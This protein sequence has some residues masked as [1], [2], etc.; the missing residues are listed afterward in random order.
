MN[1]KE[2]FG[3]LFEGLKILASRPIFT[4]LSLVLWGLLVAVSEFGAVIAVNFQSTFSNLAWTIVAALVA[5]S[6]VSYFSSGMVGLIKKKGLKEFSRTGRRSW[7]KNLVVIVSVLLMSVVVWAIAHYGALFFG[8]M[9]DLG[10]VSALVVF[11][12]IYFAGLVSFL[13]F[14]SFASFFL[15]LKNLSVAES[16]KRS[17][18]FVKESY[19]ATLSLL[20]VFFILYWLVGLISG[21]VGDLI[22][23]GILLPYAIIVFTRFVK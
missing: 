1:F 10:V 4:V 7:K 3:N 13:I 8:R 12:L 22:A 2:F 17:F 11:V 14:F 6:L 19:L 23:F 16:I 20:V 9:F 21:W 18:I 5:L 15:V